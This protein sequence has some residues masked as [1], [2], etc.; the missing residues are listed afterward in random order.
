M[1]DD[2][3]QMSKF[4]LSSYMTLR[5]FQGSRTISL[6]AFSGG[7]SFSIWDSNQR[8]APVDSI[9]L[10]R[11]VVRM[12]VKTLKNIIKAQPN[13]IVPFWQHTWDKSQNG[14]KGGW[15]K[16]NM[17]KIIKD[18]KQT[19]ALEISTPKIE[20]P[21]KVTFRG[22]KMSVD[23]DDLTDSQRSESGLMDLI[24]VLEKETPWLRLLSRLNMP[25]PTFKSN[26]KSDTNV[27]SEDNKSSYVNDDEAPY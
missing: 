11:A 7:V 21:I 19:Y 17:F 16:G 2:A 12:L 10:S 20:V 5:E 3:K 6:N 23:T 18:D 25:K 13:T 15:V 9:P 22:P 24:D 4:N 14:G 8:G 26:T 1:S 27:G